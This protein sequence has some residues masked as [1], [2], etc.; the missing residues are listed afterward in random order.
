MLNQEQLERYRQQIKLPEIGSIGQ[1]K[2][3][4][5]R[6]L[7]VGVGGLGSP[8]AL[9]LAAAGIGNI[10]LVDDEL[11]ELSNLQRQIL[12]NSAQVGQTKVAV[13]HAQLHALNPDVVVDTYCARVNQDNVQDLV[14]RYDII[15][16]GSDNFATRYL[17]HDTCYAL[18]KPYVYA[19]A[20]QFMGYCSVFSGTH[21]PC[22]RC[23]FPE[24][25]PA[26]ACFNCDDGG[27]LGPV[28]GILGLIQ[29]T[30]IIKCLANIGNSLQ[31]RLLKV[32]LLAMNFKK[33]DLTQNADCTVCGDK[34]T[35]NEQSFVANE[36][37]SAEELLQQLQQD[38][39]L[40]LVDVRT[41]EEHQEY[42]IG[43]KLI[44]LA[45]L[46]SRLNELDKAQT[47]VLYCRSGKRS[48][49]AVNLLKQVGFVNVRHLQGGVLSIKAGSR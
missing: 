47:I 21:G 1:Y 2:L 33:T 40:C 9:Y 10:G 30:E 14:R 22:L 32:D 7:C 8:L 19:S 37:V 25:P 24:E 17:L 46:P 43:G 42:N 15:A 23:I 3:Q 29:A 6:V 16:D 13:A 35:Q 28:P 26:D 48:L 38:P 20:S 4:Q 39:K 34:P 5:A 45:E 49:T 36:E 44:P 18:E 12:F 31:K 27:V 41:P 11:I